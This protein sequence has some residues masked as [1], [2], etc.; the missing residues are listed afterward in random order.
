M[1]LDEA[2]A[3]LAQK[4]QQIKVLVQSLESANANVAKL[5]HQIEKYI[6]RIYGSSSEK[7][8]P[9]QLFLDLILQNSGNQ[10]TDPAPAA[11]ELEQPPSPTKPLCK[12]TP[13]GRLPI[14]DHLERH[15]IELDVDED[16]KVCPETGEPLVL[17]GYDESEK[18]EYTPGCI[19]VN[20]YRRPKYGS[21]DR[22]KSVKVGVVSA[23]MPDHPIDK[24]KADIGLLSHIIVSKFCDHLPLY[25]QD[26]IFLRDE[27]ITIPRSTQCGWLMQTYEAIQLLGGVLKDVIFESDVLFTDDS[28]IPLIEK[29]RGS[30]RQARLWVYIRG[31]PAPALA[32]YDFTIDRRKSRP[33]DFLGDYIGYIHADAY[34][35][36]DELFR[37]EGVIEVGCWAHARRKFDEAKNSRPL[38]ATEVLGRIAQLY[39]VE[40]LCL[41]QSPDERRALRQEK[42]VPLLDGLFQRLRDLRPNTLPSEPLYTAIGYALNQE[43]ALWRY[44][45]DGRLELDNNTAENAIRP[46][47][48]GRK[49]W[50]FVGSERGGK[51]AAL[52]LSLIQSC[53]A[54]DVNPWEYFNDMLRRIMSHPANRLRELLPDQW[55]PLPKDEH[56]LIINQDR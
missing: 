55:R 22:S 31:D 8:D 41:S 42:A 10:P 4:D 48:L 1:S 11:P 43:K 18:L 51:A 36:Y 47:A 28:V 3:E 46:L 44:L 26:G 2:L 38:E 14:P 29:G 45:E 30:V 25:R 24:C 21:P 9:N 34:S 6:R 7:Y 23:P 17:I 32:V 56:G 20:V 52:Y 39:Q 53:K 19:R 33:I 37:K 35:G 16:Q 15:I 40:K 54:C 13:H 50:M 27:G 12:H 5:Q 49:N